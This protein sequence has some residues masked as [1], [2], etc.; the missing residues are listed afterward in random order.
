LYAIQY[1]RENEGRRSVVGRRR[2]KSHFFAT[3]L[4][5]G[6]EYNKDQDVS[7]APDG[8]KTVKTTD[9]TV[10]ADRLVWK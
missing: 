9:E 2:R 6:E 5:Q 4:H 10:Q 7:I 1:T 3:L 8:G